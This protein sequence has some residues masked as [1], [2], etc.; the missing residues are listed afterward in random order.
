MMIL[1]PISF[2]AMLGLCE[3][4][5]HY[6]SPYSVKFR[7]PEKELL[8]DILEGERGDP[9]FQSKIPFD[10]WASDSTR[11][12]YGAWGP[13]LKSHE[14]P[15]G[16]ADRSAEWKRERILALALRYRGYSYQHHHL[17][18]WEPPTGWPWK[19]VCH[20]QNAKGIDCSNFT[21]FVY[22]VGLGLHFTSAI[23]PQSEATEAV[24]GGKK[25]KMERIAKPKTVAECTK[26][27]KTGDLLFIENKEGDVS[28]VVIWV[29]AIGGDAPLILDSTGTGHKD[30]RGDAIPDGVQL[31]P[32]R[33]TGWYFK[34]LR[35]VH[36]IIAD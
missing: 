13:P 5:K 22:D 18:D 28:H 33:E 6:T 34:S 19:E 16:I 27:L 25:V 17:P 2:L 21:T 12:K 23:V 36:R 14:P 3:H 8:K 7:H 30:S 11:K 26:T 24:S 29:G 9:K 32:F 4:P 1:L 20:G 15:M 31:R 35:H 10:G